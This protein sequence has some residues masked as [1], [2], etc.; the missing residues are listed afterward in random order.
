[1]HDTPGS[2]ILSFIPLVLMSLLAAGGGYALAKNKGRPPVAWAL[3]CLMPFINLT[4]L[5]FLIGSTSPRLE[6][7]LDALLSER[8]RLV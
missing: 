6:K 4:F 7:K 2:L 3:L 1:M 5:M 8:D